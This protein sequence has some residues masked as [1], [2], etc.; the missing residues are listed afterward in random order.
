MYIHM[1]KKILEQMYSLNYF[2]AFIFSILS[3]SALG[4][5]CDNPKFLNLLGYDSSSISQYQ[6]LMD[7]ERKV[8]KKLNSVSSL[9]AE[10][11]VD[12]EAVV[13]EETSFVLFLKEDTISVKS[14]YSYSTPKFAKE[15]VSEILSS[16]IRR[17]SPPSIGFSFATPKLIAQ[18]KTLNVIVETGATPALGLTMS[19]LSDGTPVLQA[20]KNVTGKPFQLKSLHFG[21]DNI[22]NF[23]RIVTVGDVL[24]L[25]LNPNILALADQPV[26]LFLENSPHRYII[27]QHG[28]ISDAVVALSMSN[29]VVKTYRNL[30]N[31][32]QSSTK[33]TFYVRRLPGYDVDQRLTNCNF[34]VSGLIEIK[35]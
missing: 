5:A 11:K 10:N 6:V 28:T 7:P 20:S 27:T 31:V 25:P 22:F 34:F 15:N 26:G 33:L 14:N 17:L 2:F 19:T 24:A 29:M 30:L 1:G 35:K 4:V 16:L 32:L 8:Y 3:H 13:E 9:W 12:L 21:N 18:F 23:P